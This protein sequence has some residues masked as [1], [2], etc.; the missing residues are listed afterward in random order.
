[1]N[2]FRNLYFIF[3]LISRSELADV[4][5]HYGLV[6]AGEQEVVRVL[7]ETLQRKSNTNTSNKQLYQERSNYLSDTK[8]SIEK[9]LILNKELASRYRDV[10]Y[11]YYEIKT[12]LMGK[13]EQRLDAVARV[14]DTRQL[15]ELQ[16]RL[17]DAL[18]FYFG[19][20]SKTINHLFLLFFSFISNTYI[21]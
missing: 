12:H 10:L 16:T 1:M 5:Y 8:T 11:T 20:K 2:L 19:I 9:A 7:Q 3:F 13:L 15:I 21:F 18:N 4:N 6:E 14:K 17:H